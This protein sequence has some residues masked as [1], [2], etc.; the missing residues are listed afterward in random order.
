MEGTS[1][2]SKERFRVHRKF[3]CS[4][5]EQAMLAEA[6][7]RILPDNCLSLVERN[8]TA[9]N[10]CSSESKPVLQE[11]TKLLPKYVTATGGHR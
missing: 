9:I 10:H 3:E 8:S 1:Q 4:R 5:I 7:R 11:V 6:Y 2:G